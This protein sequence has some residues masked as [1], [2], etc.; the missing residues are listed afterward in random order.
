MPQKMSNRASFG[1]KKCLLVS[2]LFMTITVNKIYHGTSMNDRLLCC[3]RCW[4]VRTDWDLLIAT[5]LVL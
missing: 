3:T 2:P 4:D 1:Q 5:P